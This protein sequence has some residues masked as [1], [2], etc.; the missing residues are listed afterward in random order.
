MSESEP[1]QPGPGRQAA[2]GDALAARILA[3]HRVLTDLNADAE[4]RIRLHQRLTAICTSLKVPGANAG[5]ISQRLDT[6]LADAGRAQRG[7][8]EAAE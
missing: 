8:R 2:D 4:V 6:L 3:A 1:A 5:R 7:N